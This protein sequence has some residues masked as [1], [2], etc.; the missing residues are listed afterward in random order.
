[1]PPAETKL[2]ALD[3]GTS[4]FRAHRID[5]HGKVLETRRTADGILSVANKAFEA[6]LRDNI[7]DWLDASVPCIASGMITSRNGWI[8][9][10]YV[11]CPATFAALAAGLVHHKL[12]DGVEIAFAPGVRTP[13]GIRDVIRGE[14]VQILG[15]MADGLALQPG[16]HSKWARVENGAITDFVTFMTGE[17]FAVMLEH[18]ILG[19]LAEGRSHDE[20][21]FADGVAAGAAAGV[22]GTLAHALFG[23]R[24]LALAEKLPARCVSSYVSGVLIGCEL[25][26]APA[27]I[28]RADATPLLIGDATL[29]ARYR[30]AFAVLG[31][32]VELYE[33]DATIEGL[34][35]LAR[36]MQW[37]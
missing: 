30:E 21:A 7:G 32:K 13:A 37:L 18:S 4:S 34:L 16:T 6:K 28:G 26:A 22:A 15:V 25:E 31:R 36:S 9:T 14:E 24:S 5:A 17:I 11:S 1:M 29:V 19:R 8:E 20:H 10:P 33:G 35:K 12:G 3:W 2:I 27:A 23:G